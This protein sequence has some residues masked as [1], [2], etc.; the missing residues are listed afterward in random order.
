[1]TVV[2]EWKN[3]EREDRPHGIPQKIPLKTFSPAVVTTEEGL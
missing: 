1:M 2:M 3:V